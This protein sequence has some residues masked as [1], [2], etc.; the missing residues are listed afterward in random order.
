MISSIIDNEPIDEAQVLND[1]NTLEEVGKPNNPPAVD[2]QPEEVETPD[3]ETPDEVETADEEETLDPK[4]EVI[5]DDKVSEALK[6]QERE[7][8]KKY[9]STISKLKNEAT[10]KSHTDE[11]I[12]TLKS[13]GY[14]DEQI[15]VLTKLSNS[16]VTDSRIKD[17]EEAEKKSFLSENKSLSRT[18][19][20]EIEEIKA[21][22]PDMAWESARN[23]YLAE[24]APEKLTIVK[25]QKPIIS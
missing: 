24:N 1:I 25:K 7:L 14:D 6:K 15:N 9:L 17:I 4:E 20:E 13:K 16:I 8:K 12:E 5:E 11:A 23:L 3:T 2:Q 21:T 18:E 10:K 19:I 22:F